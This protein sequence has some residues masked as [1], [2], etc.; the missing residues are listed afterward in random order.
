MT[1]TTK[2]VVKILAIVAILVLAMSMVFVGCDKKTD[3]NEKKVVILVQNGEEFDSYEL[4]TTSLYLSDALKELQAENKL[5]YSIG[6]DGTSLVTI[7]ELETTSDWSKW[8]CIYHN[9]DDVAL[10]F[11]GY[12][13]ELEG[14]IY[15]SSAEGVTT[16]PLQNGAKYLFRQ[17]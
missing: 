17:M 5:T 1:R 2:N 3:P 8:I 16:C 4:T 14:V 15:H 10:F 7:N 6:S 13:F 9:I 12:D 11:P